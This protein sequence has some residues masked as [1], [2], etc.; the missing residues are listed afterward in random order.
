MLI[1][2]FVFY[3]IDNGVGAEILFNLKM[4]F[5]YSSSIMSCEVRAVDLPTYIYIYIYIG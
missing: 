5:I 3:I 2:I 1:I 4:G